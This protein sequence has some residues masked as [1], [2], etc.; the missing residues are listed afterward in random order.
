MFRETSVARARYARFRFLV[1]SQYKT[2]RQ[3]C[4]VAFG[5]QPEKS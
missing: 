4:P 3:G 1:G 5:G 2:I